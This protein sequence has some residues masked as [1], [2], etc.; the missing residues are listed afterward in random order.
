VSIVAKPTKYGGIHFRSRLEATWAAFFDL[1]AWGWEYEPFN[2]GRWLPDF[3]L[4]APRAPGGVVL[5]EVKPTASA[6]P[7]SAVGSKIDESALAWTCLLLGVGPRDGQ[8]D[9]DAPM[10]I[11][12]GIRLAND[13]EWTTAYLQRSPFGADFCSLAEHI[14][15]LYGEEGD[16]FWFSHCRLLWGRAKHLTRYEP[17]GN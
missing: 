3:S 10:S 1:L 2:V 6:Y 9:L 11:L 7:G 5:V 16:F 8:L 14:P 12:G 13:D 15:V 4:T 17:H